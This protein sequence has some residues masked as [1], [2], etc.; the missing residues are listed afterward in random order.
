MK[1][2]HL[3]FLACSFALVF[4]GCGSSSTEPTLGGS[5]DIELTKPGNKWVGSIRFNGTYINTPAEVVSERREN[6]ITTLRFTIDLTGHPDSALISQ[7]VPAKYKDERGRV[8]A[9]MKVRMTTEGIEDYSQDGKPWM[10]V[11]YDANVGDTY[12]FNG[13]NGE[14]KKRTVVERTNQDDWPFGFLLIK[15]IKV[16]EVLPPKDAVAS[17][18]WYRANHRFG[19]VY[20]E[21]FLKSGGSVSVSLMTLA[22]V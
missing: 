3:L 21:T 11:R 18:I 8:T 5:S 20:M 10:L 17:K 13:P 1:S 9:S 19:L 15:T 7:Y 6:G 12:T 14:I 16:E 4:S 22:D 2:Y